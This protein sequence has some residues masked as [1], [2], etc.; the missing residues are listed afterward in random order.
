MNT[1]ENTEKFVKSLVKDVFGIEVTTSLS[2]DL[3]GLNCEITP[4]KQDDRALLIGFKGENIGAVRRLARVWGKK[5]DMSLH[6]F[7]RFDNISN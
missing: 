4:T 1:F 6:V 3:R 5:N 7:I 2:S